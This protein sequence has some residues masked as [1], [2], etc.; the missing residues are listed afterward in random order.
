M[1]LLLLSMKTKEN[2]NGNSQVLTF[3][4]KGRAKGAQ[5]DDSVGQNVT[6]LIF[7][8]VF[9]VAILMSFFEAAYVFKIGGFKLF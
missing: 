2:Y 3:L 4:K 9:V 8:S 1:L 5:M 7:R 6:S